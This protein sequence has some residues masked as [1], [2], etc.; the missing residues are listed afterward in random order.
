MEVGVVGEV[1]QASTL[2]G[3]TIESCDYIPP[4]CMLALGK[5]EKGAYMR[6]PNI[7]V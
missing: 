5:S 1:S 3:N 2:K 4:L 7:S 6:D